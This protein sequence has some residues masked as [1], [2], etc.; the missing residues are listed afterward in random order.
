[1][2]DQGRRFSICYHDEEIQQENYSTTS[3][4]DYNLL[5]VFTLHL[6]NRITTKLIRISETIVIMTVK[7][8]QIDGFMPKIKEMK[9]MLNVI[10]C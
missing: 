7:H 4:A 5:I 3:I 1:M 8:T 9:V 10:F 2:K 6:L